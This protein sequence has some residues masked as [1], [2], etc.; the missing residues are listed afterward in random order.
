MGSYMED[1][2]N[3]KT[4]KTD[5]WVLTWGLA[6][7]QDNTVVGQDNTVVGQGGQNELVKFWT[8]RALSSVK[9]LSRTQ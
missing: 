5:E 1:L 8:I 6:L 2:K 4:F 9:P 7:V 3:H